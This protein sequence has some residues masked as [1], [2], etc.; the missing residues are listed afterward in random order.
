ML[1]LTFKN[2]KTF[3]INRI[4]GFI[5]DDDDDDERHLFLIVQIKCYNVMIVVNKE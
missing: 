3:S 5:D 1:Y 4:I 2:D